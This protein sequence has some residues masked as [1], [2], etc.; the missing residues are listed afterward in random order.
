MQSA[1]ENDE[2]DL[3]DDENFASS[4]K[5]ARIEK[6]KKKVKYLKICQK[7]QVFKNKFIFLLKDESHQRKQSYENKSEDEHNESRSDSELKNKQIKVLQETI[8]NLQRKLIETSTKEKQNEAKINDLEES[9]RESNVKELLL[10][11][12]IANARTTSQSVT[13]DDVSETSSIAPVDAG[14]HQ[15]EPQI[16]SLATAFLVIHPQ[17]V[18]IESIFMYVRQFVMPIAES[19]ILDVLKRNEKLFNFIDENKLQLWFYCGFKR[20]YLRI[21][22]YGV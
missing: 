18:D 12:K 6:P 19:E 8:R 4:S 14:N 10:R 7:F 3:S 1:D 11:T 22:P 5:R 21:S 16:I 20:E 13:N 9:V 17:G 2:M 15:F